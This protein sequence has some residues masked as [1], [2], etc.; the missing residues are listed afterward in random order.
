M[1]RNSPQDG[2]E[3]H[4]KVTFPAM[5]FPVPLTS[6]ISSVMLN[7]LS[8]ENSFCL[9]NF[10][11]II[12]MEQSFQP[13]TIMPLRNFCRVRSPNLGGSALLF[14]HLT[15][16]CQQQSC[17]VNILT[18]SSAIS[19]SFTKILPKCHSAKFSLQIHEA[20]NELLQITS[21]EY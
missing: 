11:S 15:S 8:N 5:V 12:Q 2:T 13:T 16:C 9:S 6:D 14:T 18:V 19:P 4:S 7:N 1:Q 3:R 21:S 20:L 10:M 17:W